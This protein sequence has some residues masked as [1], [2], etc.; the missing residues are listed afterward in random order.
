MLELRSSVQSFIIHLNTKNEEQK[1]AVWNM[2]YKSWEFSVP[3]QVFLY[4]SIC[5]VIG[6]IL[7]FYTSFE[8]ILAS[9]IVWAV[10][11]VLFLIGGSHSLFK[12]QVSIC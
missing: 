12:L 2:I 11:S 8:A 10:G 9:E 1:L 3:T 4:G 7:F 5:Y 6:S